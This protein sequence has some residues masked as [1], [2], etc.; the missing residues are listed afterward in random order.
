MSWLVDGILLAVMILFVLVGVKRGFVRSAARL[1]GAILAAFLAAALAG[2]IA[3]WLFEW[4]FRQ[5]LVEKIGETISGVG[6]QGLAESMGQVLGSLPDFIVRALTDAGVTV[7]ALEGIV[8][9]GAGEAAELVTDTLSP[10]FIGF[11]KVAVLLILFLLLMIA[12]RALA[13]VLHSVA[14]LPLLRQVDQLL[15]GVCGLLLAV[16]VIWVALGAIRVFLPMLTESTQADMESMIGQSV[17]AKII[18]GW[19]PL[20]GLFK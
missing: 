3:K 1:A 7:G 18:T 11:I 14:R 20:A 19:N 15:G 5:S 4:L 17:I 13:E 10:V 6:T 2:P 16:V 9:H 12:V 8:A